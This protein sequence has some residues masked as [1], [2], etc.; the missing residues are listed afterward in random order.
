MVGV[1]GG[2][3]DGGGL[4]GTALAGAVVV[5]GLRG[6]VDGYSKITLPIKEQQKGLLLLCSTSC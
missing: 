4:R 5:V 2:R 6:G 3:G 1:G